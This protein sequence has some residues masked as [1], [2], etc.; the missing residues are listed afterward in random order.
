MSK[1]TLSILHTSDVHLD[2]T[3]GA[4]GDESHGQRGF[5][6][7]ID[8]AIALEVDLFLLAGDLFDHNRV[9]DACVEF[10]SRQLSRLDC[11]VIMITGNHDCLSDYSIYHRYDPADAGDH[12]RFIRDEAGGLVDMPE[13]GLSIWGRGIVDHHPGNRPLENVPCREHDGWYIGMA[14]GYYVERGGDMRSSLI[15]PE[16]ISSSGLDYLALGHV[17]VFTEIR[18]GE[19]VAA[20][21]GSPNR[22]QAGTNISAAFVELD[23]GDG[24]RVS[25]LDL[26]TQP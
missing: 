22:N 1:Q 15:K 19:T 7:V 12:V 24:V 25:R 2:D 6:H 20:Y 5:R 11:P 13:L 9:K 21:P 14:H 26:E 8:R 17:H 16:E 4:A 23:P 10:A 18:A 3:P